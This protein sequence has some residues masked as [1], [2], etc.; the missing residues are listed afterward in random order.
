MMWRRSATRVLTVLL[1]ILGWLVPVCAD[2]PAD[3]KNRADEFLAFAKRESDTY[4]FRLDARGGEP[5]R[6]QPEPILKW[7]NPVV[8]TIYGDVF[9]WTANGRPELVGSLYQWYSPYTHRSN[10][11]MSLSTGR[12]TAEREGQVVWAPP[13]SGIDFKPLPGAAAPAATAPQR[14]RQMRD[15]ASEFT[16]RQTDRK[17]VERD[18]RLLAQPVY[19]YEGAGGEPID[20]ALFVFVLGTDP[21]AFLLIE[22]RKVEGKPQWQYALARMNSIE[23]HVSQRGHEVWAVSAIPYASVAD[24]SGPYTTFQ[25]FPVEAARP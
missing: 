22:D 23:L 18:M 14:L 4:T 13:P 19:R 10:E 15:M 5:L 6:R 21:E 9:V 1:P 11:F 3:E 24:H 2:E 7:S 20:G 17:G 8:G 12:L 25:F 16:A